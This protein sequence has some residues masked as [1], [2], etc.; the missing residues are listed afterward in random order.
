MCN[1]LI[2]EDH[3]NW[4]RPPRTVHYSLNPVELETLL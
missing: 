2:D 4:I 1:N 3:E